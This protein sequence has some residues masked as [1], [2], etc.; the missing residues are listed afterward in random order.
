MIDR[1]TPII[2]GGRITAEHIKEIEDITK[3]GYTAEVRRRGQGVI[4]LEVK[5]TIKCDTQ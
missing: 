5:K 2:E 1:S 3:R 4:V